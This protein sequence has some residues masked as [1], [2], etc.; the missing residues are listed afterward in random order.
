MKS[1]NT[2]DLLRIL[3]PIFISESIESTLYRTLLRKSLLRFLNTKAFKKDK[4]VK[5]NLPSGFEDWDEWGAIVYSKILATAQLHMG[6][7]GIGPH[8]EIVGDKT[9]QKYFREI[10]ANNVFNKNG[11]QQF[12]KD[13]W[14]KLFQALESNE[15]VSSKDA[16]NFFRNIQRRKE[17]IVYSKRKALI[18]FHWIYLDESEYPNTPLCR[19]RDNDAIRVLSKHENGG[20]NEVILAPNYSRILG[21]LGLIKCK[22][23]ESYQDRAKR[24]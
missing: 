22:K 23:K 8:E 10:T 15:V 17:G 2:E 14:S 4:S 7:T 1:R 9:A 19:L 24:G 21:D 3:Y 18:V 16:S 13:D 20:T 5:Y 6:I 12:S 11:S